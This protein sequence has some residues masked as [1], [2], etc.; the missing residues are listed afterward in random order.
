MQGCTV[1]GVTVQTADLIADGWKEWCLWVGNEH[2]HGRTLEGRYLG[3]TR[4]V[5]TT[6]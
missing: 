3:F 6:N 4:V 5:A 1:D 2:D